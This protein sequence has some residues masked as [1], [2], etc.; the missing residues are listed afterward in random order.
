ML[1]R[2]YH[3]YAVMHPE[4]ERLQAYLAEHGVS[5]MI[6][7]PLPPHKQE[8]FRQWNGLSFP[9]TEKIHRQELSLPMSP[10]HSDE[11]ISYVAELINSFI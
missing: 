3:I 10:V 7:Y 2:S 9:I 1:F 11:E 8:A 6:H 4:R 5:T